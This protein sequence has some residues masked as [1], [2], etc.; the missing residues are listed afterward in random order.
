MSCSNKKVYFSGNLHFNENQLKVSDIE[1]KIVLTPWSSTATPF[2]NLKKSLA[3]PSL[4]HIID[5]SSGEV[6]QTTANWNKR[7]ALRYQLLV[8]FPLSQRR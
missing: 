3:C 5:I 8:R 7:C 6:C 1:G 2:D 4:I